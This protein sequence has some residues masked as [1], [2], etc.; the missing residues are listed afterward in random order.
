M[1]GSRFPDIPHTETL[2]DHWRELGY[3]QP[4]PMGGCTGFE[5]QEVAAYV[6]ITQADISPIEAITLVDMSKAYSSGLGDTNPLS[7]EPMKRGGY[8]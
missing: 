4:L 6:Q 1:Y 3:A 5:W 7:K 8:D 2:I